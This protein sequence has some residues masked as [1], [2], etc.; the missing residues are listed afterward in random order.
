VLEFYVLPLKNRVTFEC[1]PEKKNMED[2]ADD[3]SC[4][5]IEN[6]KIQEKEALTPLSGSEN[7]RTSNIN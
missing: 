4:F 3:L 2:A 7:C 6:L 1:F 5:E